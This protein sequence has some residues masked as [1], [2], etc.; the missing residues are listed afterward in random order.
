M[1]ESQEEDHGSYRELLKKISHPLVDVRS[2]AL[3]SIKFKLSS[4]LITA[5]QL[6]NER[7]FLIHL[8]EWFNHEKWIHEGLALEI[9]R[10]ATEFEAAVTTLQEV[11]GVEFLSQ[12]RP[13][14]NPSCQ[15][16]VDEMLEKLL[17]LPSSFTDH[18]HTSSS[19][20]PSIGS[21]SPITSPSFNHTHIHTHQTASPNSDHTHSTLSIGSN[22]S[23]T[24]LL[25][26]DGPK[27]DSVLATP[28][29][30]RDSL[31]NSYDATLKLGSFPWLPLSK[32]D[33][34]VL[35][36]T[37][38][39][40]QSGDRGCVTST[41]GFIE[42]VLLNDFP[43]EVFLQRPDI[44]EHLLEKLKEDVH[45]RTGDHTP[46]LS[47]LLSL[48]H[49]L[50]GRLEVQINPLAQDS[51]HLFSYKLL[52]KDVEDHPKDML[53]H[54]ASKEISIQTFCCNVLSVLVDLLLLSLDRHLPWLDF[55]CRSHDFP[56]DELYSMFGRCLECCSCVSDLLLILVK[57]HGQISKEK[58]IE[59]LDVFA[60]AVIKCLSK[61]RRCRESG[62]TPHLLLK[63]ICPLAGLLSYWFTLLL[64]HSS[65][66]FE[67][68][69]KYLLSSQV[70]VVFKE[71]L[72]DP[73]VNIIINSNNAILGS[74]DSFIQ[75]TDNGLCNLLIKERALCS[76]FE[77][78][79]RFLSFFDE[80]KPTNIMPIQLLEVAGDSLSG[81]SFCWGPNEKRFVT[82]AIENISKI[83][84]SGKGDDVDL[85]TKCHKF[86]INL[87]SHERREVKMAAYKSYKVFLE[88]SCTR[89]SPVL[90]PS[91]FVLSLCQDMLSEDLKGLALPLISMIV[92]DIKKNN[93][94]NNNNN[95]KET[96][97]KQLQTLLQSL[98]FVEF[99][100]QSSHDNVLPLIYIL[101]DCASSQIRTSSLLRMLYSKIKSIR[102]KSFDKLMREYGEK[103]MVDFSD[104][105]LVSSPL[106]PLLHFYCPS[107]ALSS[108]TF[109]C[110]DIC[111][112]LSVAGSIKVDVSLRVS[113]LDQ[114]SSI[115]KDISL[116][117]MAVREGLL[118]LL[119]RIILTDQT[120]TVKEREDILSSSL[121][122]LQLLVL[123]SGTV[124]NV[125]V[126]N[127]QFMFTLFR[128]SFIYKSIR[129]LVSQ[130]ISLIVFSAILQFS[131]SP[132]VN[133]IKMNTLFLPHIQLPFSVQ[134]LSLP[135]ST[136]SPAPT[137]MT[138]S[139]PNRR[140]L[141]LHYALAVARG[142][143]NIPSANGEG[144]RMGE[145]PFLKGE[146]F[147]FGEDITRLELSNVLFD[148]QSLLY[149]S[150]YTMAGYYLSLL[151]RPVK[152]VFPVF[153]SLKVSLLLSPLSASSHKSL[154][155]NIQEVFQKFLTKA[156]K[157]KEDE[158]IA[159]STLSCLRS[160]SSNLIG[161]SQWEWLLSSVA[162]KDGFLVRHLFC[163]EEDTNKE[164]VKEF[165]LFVSQ[166]L[167]EAPAHNV[168]L[169]LI[170][171]QVISSD[172]NDRSVLYLSLQCIL[173]ILKN[174]SRNNV[175]FDRID[176]LSS[177]MASVRKLIWSSVTER[178]TSFGSFMLKGITRLCVQCLS[179]LLF[180]IHSMSISNDKDN[181]DTIINWL[182]DDNSLLWIHSLLHDRDN[183]VS[184]ATY[185]ILSI[186]SSQ[187]NGVKV[188]LRSW[189]ELHTNGLL[190]AMIDT[191]MS[192]TES[193]WIRHQA[194][195]ISVNIIYHGEYDNDISELMEDTG[196]MKCL[197]SAFD[198]L[199]A[200]CDEILTLEEAKKVIQESQSLDHQD[201]Q[202]ER[203]GLTGFVDWKVLTYR[204][205][206]DCQ[207]L[208]V[209]GMCQFV[210]IA[211][212][213][214]ETAI[215]A[216]V[217][218][219]MVTF[220]IRLLKSSIFK[221]IFIISP[222]LWDNL[223]V[224]WLDLYIRVIALL[225]VISVSTINSSC[226]ESHDQGIMSHD[227]LKATASHS[228][229]LMQW[230]DI[231]P[232]GCASKFDA[233]CLEIVK[234]LRGLTEEE[235]K[236][237][238][239]SERE[240]IV[241]KCLIEE[242]KNFTE[243]LV[244]SLTFEI[245]ELSVNCLTLLS[246][247]LSR[248]HV[249]RP[250]SSSSQGS[251]LSPS[252]SSSFSSLS[253]SSS[254]SASRSSSLSFSLL[255]ALDSDT[256]RELSMTLW[257]K[258]EVKPVEGENEKL[259]LV[260]EL[261][262][263]GL[264]LLLA[265]SQTAK[266]IMMEAGL[267]ES[268][269]EQL[270]SLH[271]KL[272]VDSLAKSSNRKKKTVYT[273]VKEIVKCFK[274]LQNALHDNN[275]LKLV[276]VK[277]GLMNA[278]SILWPSIV[279]NMTLLKPFL[280][281]LTVFTAHCPE[282]HLAM[283]NDGKGPTV[284]SGVSLY[285]QLL[286][287]ASLSI[288]SNM[289][290]TSTDQC[291][292]P[293]YSLVLVDLFSVLCNSVSSQ[294]CR[295][296]IKKTNFLSSFLLINP[297][298]DLAKHSASSSPYLL[299]TEWLHLLVNYTFTNDGMSLVAKL[300]GSVD[301][302]CD[303]WAHLKRRR[304]KLNCVAI[305]RNLCFY[306]PSKAPLASNEK[307]M[308]I[309]IKCLKTEE[310]KFIKVV[311]VGVHSL[312]YNCSKTK[313]LIKHKFLH[314]ELSKTFNSLKSEGK[315]LADQV[316]TVLSMIGQ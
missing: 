215:R 116:H 206:S 126:S 62:L 105:L 43:P 80:T 36:S 51:H 216:T 99:S 118:S 303:L 120:K 68:N 71:I 247:L 128:V 271:T 187:S 313:V 4:G 273:E 137:H 222:S 305:L 123:G 16:M 47:T 213:L 28:P 288:L 66:L 111:N 266:E 78:L 234:F 208:V 158:N 212:S 35:G 230:R 155:F 316:H 100:A 149:T 315:D 38:S 255:S 310:E 295:A 276:A 159:V 192:H 240:E 167:T 74:L 268:V 293:P 101:L 258:F 195:T 235:K 301:L 218:K 17:H 199:I 19:S 285:Q 166:S 211:L 264:C 308:D 122:C 85:I 76:S 229:Q 311:T 89:L 263:I 188:L 161:R 290:S 267:V 121:N 299:V 31:N 15:E 182:D 309:F 22:L 138:S 170:L 30:T 79:Y 220:I 2:R 33:I 250:L 124:R 272:T 223:A 148:L 291:S 262:W 224:S 304:D 228:L 56:G 3:R 104:V 10:D 61:L 198:Q 283:L 67:A 141:W 219:D 279:I 202:V 297:K 193:D 225:H 107:L 14:V 42:E 257:E 110:E 98:P 157:T 233:L 163:R 32:V 249:K 176:A 151:A 34:K 109:K 127:H 245:Q 117:E 194:F 298:V 135:T 131:P 144:D 286:K 172:S 278:L 25:S 275:S 108:S 58:I 5:S 314:Q 133:V 292:P 165:L 277:A 209:S 86:L 90:F 82:L 183:Q 207:F 306:G 146:E 174:I 173:N 81:L 129:C 214:K 289:K 84:L 312:L 41:W 261:S 29:P 75:S 231:L 60:G 265:S 254:S 94:T 162:S 191:G 59:T 63:L 169:L 239:I 226:I 175:N 186:I 37:L 270:I 307:V 112:L 294:E 287:T 244:Y 205:F 119:Q 232:Q 132:P 45:I 274:L 134:P 243:L 153:E 282:A 248:C 251:I 24:H 147:L 200:N 136:T 238:A 178:G 221:F 260:R 73:F 20:H 181:N 246:R 237:E 154:S 180:I 179:Y 197:L 152:R 113:A 280:Q 302:L 70:C 296:V 8:M 39:R 204:Y 6:S 241:W 13:H 139:P 252:S 44:V 236:R 9:L 253:P 103:S 203:T 125:I 242:W 91:G 115:L 57:G 142:V 227:Q 65:H 7:R 40:L 88:G 196:L 281:L 12:L 145:G 160:I 23:Q 69:D 48:V 46:P 189:K 93:D 96:W 256:V 184:C 185:S 168:S 21:A 18:S 217:L 150:C 114:L 143:D 177:L 72:A 83:L 53:I 52:S 190:G 259:A 140:R 164:L 77:Q 201:K 55:G 1:A 102:E 284:V 50:T 64:C 54:L 300:Q 156:P 26:S 130:I 171:T 27:I 87:A 92:L 11:G 269:T 210:S 97:D 49:K 95:N 106:P